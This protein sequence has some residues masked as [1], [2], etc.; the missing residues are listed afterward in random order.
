MPISTGTP[1]GGGGGAPS[2]PA[3]GALSGTY[4]NPAV[5]AVTETSGPTDLTIGAIADGGYVKRSGAT[6][7]SGAPVV[8]VAATDASIVVG[9]TAA[10]PTLATGTL[11]A[12]ATLHPPVAAV[13]F[14]G[15]KGTGIGNGTA[16][17][18]IAAFGQIPTALPPNGTAG[19]DLGSTFPNPTVTAIHE[20]SG[21]TKLTIGSIPDGNYLK[22]SGSTLVADAGPTAPVSSVFGR[23]GAVTDAANQVLLTTTPT[24]TASTSALMLGAAGSIT[25]Q[26]TR[27]FVAIA[28]KYNN[29]ASTTATLKLEGR[30]GTGTAPVQNAAVTG[31]AF[32]TAMT[33]LE[34]AATARMIP[35]TLI[36]IVTGLT[37]GVA[38]WLDVAFTNGDGTNAPQ[39]GQVTLIA[40][41]V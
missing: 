36:G 12:V 11:D 38:Y 30:Y 4:P 21:P 23:T 20:T 17:Q 6:L 29:S 18:D 15:Q 8:S 13:P 25:P 22:R 37:A 9:G 5:K 7:V 31:T 24:L 32:G 10:A 34:T 16:A 1:G 3:G 33:G 41:D 26:G 14:N 28:G 19:G 39:I 2:G 27:I 40:F 35:F